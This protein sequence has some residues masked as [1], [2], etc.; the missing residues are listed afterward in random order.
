M[1]KQIIQE[2][3]FS[4]IVSYN[5]LDNKFELKQYEKLIK[6]STYKLLIKEIISILRSIIK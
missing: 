6:R 4:E 3:E 5:N 1:N 2:K